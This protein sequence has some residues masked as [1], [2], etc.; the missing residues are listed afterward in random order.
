VASGAAD[1]RV[2]LW[3]PFTQEELYSLEP[4][5]NNHNPIETLNFSPDGTWL[6]AGGANVI[7]LWRR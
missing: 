1:G 6:V 7:Q 5:P 2:K 3:D 4:F